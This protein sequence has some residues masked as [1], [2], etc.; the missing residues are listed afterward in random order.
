VTK[1]TVVIAGSTAHTTQCAETLRVD[2]RFEVVGVLTPSPKPTGRKQLLTPNPLQRWA[3]QHAL[4]I[5]FVDKKIDESAKE[6]VTRVFAVPPTFLLVVDFGYLIPGW[7]LRWP[8]IAPVNI[9][10]SALPKYRGSSPGQFALMFGEKESAVTVMVMDAKLDHG[11]IIKQLPFA[12]PASWTT[13]EYYDHAFQLVCKE[14]PSILENFGAKATAVTV[15]PDLS[16]TP[17]AHML[18]REDG[19]VPL[20]VLKNLESKAT[21]SEIVPFLE[22]HGL[23][24]TT[25]T[26]FSLWRGLTPWPGIWTTIQKDGAEKR[27]KILMLKPNQDHLE[28]ARIQFEGRLPETYTSSSFE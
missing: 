18:K 4:P 28:I 27:V 10:P 8:V 14:L 13:S 9:H 26:V 17:T 2:T 21:T 20:G 3:E 23:P 15:Q 24:T 22:Q 5:V 6:K 12:V 7:L 16:P 25:E 1:Y 11:P 19:F